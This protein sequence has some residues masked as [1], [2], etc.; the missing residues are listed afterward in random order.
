VSR[1][2]PEQ[3]EVI[4]S[5]GKG[6]A[7]I[8]GAGCGK[9]TTLVAKCV[10][11]LERKPEA[12]FAAVSF[13]EK[14]AADLRDKLSRSLPRTEKGSPL[15]GHW[16]TTIHGLCGSVIREFPREAGMDGEETVLAEADARVMWER[17]LEKLWFDELPE[18]VR[19]AL[20]QLLDRESKD[21][22]ADL[23]A[24]LKSLFTFRV[25]ERFSDGDDDTLALAIVG[26]YVIDG[27][28]RAKRRRGVIDFDDL[29]RGARRALSHERVREAFHRRFDL[30]MVDEFQDTNP[31]QA[32]ILWRLARPDLSNLCVVGDP[33]Q[34][35]YRFRDADVSVF[36]E[37]CAQLSVRQKLTLN[38]RCR[39]GILDFT[40]AV[41]AR[42]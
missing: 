3:L 38:F 32:E 40:N 27:Y 10:A 24:R 35:I 12:R 23:L 31:V 28:E 41:C 15:S 22:L 2:T 19:L 42:P 20:E 5:W 16:V 17:A 4:H 9:T 18:D 14:S 39:P 26:A 13:T 6:Q 34:S 25:F 36:E 7:V 29:E 21:S 1:F 11:L 37:C 8:A 30:V 33:K